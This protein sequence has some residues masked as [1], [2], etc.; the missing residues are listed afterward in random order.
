MFK[1]IFIIFILFTILYSKQCSSCHKKE[2]Q[3]CRHSIHYTLKKAI[4]I[5][6]KTWGID[7]SN[8][9]LQTLPLPKKVIHSP[10][11]LVD[12]FLRRK[13]L[14][15]HIDT[16]K[17]EGC[18]SCHNRHQGKG[19]Y[20][21]AKASTR[22]CLS[23]HNKEYTGGEYTGLFPKDFEKSYRAPLTKKGYFPPSKYGIDY[24]HLSEDIHYKMGL[25][26][27]DCHKNLHSDSK[28][29]SC[30]DCHKK[31]SSK[32]HPPYHKNIDC[33]ACHASWQINSYELSVFRDDTPNYNKWKRL[34]M[35]EDTYLQNFLTNALKQKI[36]P[37]PVMPDWVSGKIKTGIW[38]SG[39]RY[40][41]WED[42]YLANDNDGKIKLFRPLYQYK[43]SYKDK[44]GKMVLDNV[45]KIEGR[46]IEVWLPYYPHT[47]GKYAKTCEMCHNNSLVLQPKK[48]NNDLASDLKLPSPGSLYNATPLT[49]KQIKRLFSKKYK[50]T[51]AHLFFK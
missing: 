19:T 46:N 40:R 6:R 42:F 51:R 38:Y 2:A 49:K 33:I 16:K 9:T 39:Y 34:T 35:Q 17:S 32:N 8:V 3:D 7:E 20:F 36:K 4:N 50:K 18:L 26:C 47:I 11:D 13:C 44:N 30:I 37:I 21:K 5:T 14:K 25:G 45:G 27:I 43:I 23:C 48:L 41:R 1:I 28:K 31:L 24:H 12:D 29:V 15:C 10:K 22:K